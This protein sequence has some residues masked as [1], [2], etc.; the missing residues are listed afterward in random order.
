MND[1]LPALSAFDD[2]SSTVCTTFPQR[3]METNC[4]QYLFILLHFMPYKYFFS[5]TTENQ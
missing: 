3:A 4:D 1:L 2:I 5:R